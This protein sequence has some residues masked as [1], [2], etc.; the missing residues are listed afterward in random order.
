MFFNKEGAVV[1]ITGASSGLGREIALSL[2]TKSLNLIITGRDEPRLNEVA[3]LCSSSGK[4]EVGTFIG[5]L[6]SEDTC[7]Y[8]FLHP[9]N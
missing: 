7:R 3:L 9:G 8:Y 4:T 2:S 1:I 5:D 6:T